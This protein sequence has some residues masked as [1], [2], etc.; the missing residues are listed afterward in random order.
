MTTLHRRDPE[1]RRAALISAAGE[2]IKKN[3][4]VATSVDKIVR[5]ADVAK[6]T[7]Y[8]YFKTKDDIVNA[9]V[10]QMIDEMIDRIQA[11]SDETGLPARDRLVALGEAL[12][13][14]SKEPG[15]AEVSEMFHRPENRAAHDRMAQ[16]A[17]ARLV[18][19]YQQIIADGIED[20]VFHV[21]NPRLSAWL[22]V[23]AFQAVE[24]AMSDLQDLDL[25][26]LH[27]H[28]FVL[29]GLGY[30]EKRTL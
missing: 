20:G 4:L 9:V 21:A 13:E 10:E 25:A 3:G 22:V 12:V 26:T 27:L 14:W 6:G 17:K 24:S 29:R 2:L 30:A 23:G 19:M 15:I 18:P 16:R 8:L 7:F 5:G 11:V 28:D 1:A